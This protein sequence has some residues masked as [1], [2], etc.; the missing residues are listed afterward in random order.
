[1]KLSYNVYAIDLLNELLDAGLKSLFKKATRIMKKYCSAIDNI[2]SKGFHDLYT[3]CILESD[4]SDHLPLL[5]L[6]K[7]PFPNDQNRIHFMSRSPN[8]LMHCRKHSQT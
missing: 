1:M 3:S 8:T 4:M 2:Y 6:A 7:W 5:T